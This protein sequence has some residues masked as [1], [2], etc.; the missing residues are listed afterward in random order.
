MVSQYLEPKNC[1]DNFNPL[2][3]MPL[4]NHEKKKNENFGYRCATDWEYFNGKCY[5]NS[6]RFGNAEM[7]YEEALAFC[8]N[9]GE[10]SSLAKITSKEEIEFVSK[11]ENF[12][13]DERSS[14]WVINFLFY[15]RI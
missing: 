8:S 6:Y 7:R 10:H 1:D 12:W 2:C 15:F 11:K 4:I 9:L 14:Y 5:T 13:L 3:K